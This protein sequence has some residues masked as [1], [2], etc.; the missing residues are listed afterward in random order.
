MRLGVFGGTFD[1]PH[2]G[3]RIVAR[4]AGEHLRL[5]RVI[6]VPAG[7]PPHK[8]GQVSTD[9][10]VRCDLV[11]CATEDDPLMDVSRI[12]I[13]RSG[14]SFTVDTLRSISARYPDAELFLLIGADQRAEFSRWRDPHEIANLSQVVVMNRTGFDIPEDDHGYENTGYDMSEI[15]IPRID[16]S[17]SEIRARVAERLEVRHLVPQRVWDRIEELGLY[18]SIGE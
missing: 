14:L 12:E 9:A 4:A 18:R 15:P 10:E 13:E 11:M 6:W 5:D 8:Q 7:L 2:H 17:S 1:P 3:H 16:I